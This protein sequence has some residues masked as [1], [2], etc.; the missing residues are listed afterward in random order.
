MDQLHT[1]N[2][3][4]YIINVTY[5]LPV[6][7]KFR[8][9]HDDADFDDD[10]E[11]LEDEVVD[12]DVPDEVVKRIHLP[13]GQENGAEREIRKSNY[14]GFLR[15]VVAA[16]RFEPRPT[17]QGRSFKSRGAF[18]SLYPLRSMSCNRPLSEMQLYF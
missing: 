16:Q 13:D 9:Q 3:V 2:E 6:R 18:F 15:T 17:R 14:V 7:E 11:E 4:I 10:G 8:R 5:P 1:F 12:A